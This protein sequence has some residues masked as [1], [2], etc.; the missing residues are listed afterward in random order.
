M[1][2]YGVAVQVYPSGVYEQGV[3][4]ELN[5]RVAGMS[6]NSCRMSVI[7]EVNE[8]AGVDAVDVDL[9]SGEVS[10]RGDQ[11]DDSAIQAA[12]IEA[13]YQPSVLS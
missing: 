5:Y 3:G 7:E 10:V 11:L 8:L 9:A 12:I 1:H 6:C 2:G 4:M 13:G